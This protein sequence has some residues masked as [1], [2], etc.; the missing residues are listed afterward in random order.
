MK[1]V[2]LIINPHAGK[3]QIRGELLNI[4][5]L[6]SAEGWKVVTYVTQS[7]GDA[8]QMVRH[9]GLEYDLI[10]CSGGDGTAR[11]T[12]CGLMQLPQKERPPLGYIPA[13][14][15][16]DY[17]A[18]LGLHRNMEAAARSVIHGKPFACDIGLFGEEYFTYIAAF[19]AFTAVSYQTPQQSKNVLGHLAYVLE[20]IRSI[21][22]IK[23]YHLQVEHDGVQVEEDF[24]F[25]MVSNSISVGGFK[26]LMQSGVQMDDGVFEVT[27]VRHPRTLSDLQEIIYAL[28]NQEDNQKHILTFRSSH[29]RLTCAEQLPWTLDGEF[30]GS[31]KQ[32]DIRNLKQSVCILREMEL[33]V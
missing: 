23:P 15:T 3:G 14:T 5:D 10:V 24:I 29:I 2:L 7:H 26:N 32:V 13:G 25:G 12:V 11:E 20:G 30:G 27:L 28:V 8:T 21:T 9:H 6:F 33:Y 19:G 22:S 31:V 1:R 4:L 16:N 18:S 17:A